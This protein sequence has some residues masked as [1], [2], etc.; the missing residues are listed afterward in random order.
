MP[1]TV[2]GYIVDLC[3]GPGPPGVDRGMPLV[4]RAVN[5]WSVLSISTVSIGGR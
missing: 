1:V 4:Q 3:I 2:D 5:L